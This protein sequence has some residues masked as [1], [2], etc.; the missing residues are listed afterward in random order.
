MSGYFTQGRT[1]ASAQGAGDCFR[2]SVNAAA[3]G[4]AGIVISATPGRVYRLIVQNGAATAYYVQIHNKAT[5]PINTELAIWSKRLPV[6]SEVEIDLT[7]INGLVCTT[8]I[9]IALSSTPLALTL[10]LATDIAFRSVV[11]TKKG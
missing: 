9:S 8:G 4:T 10:A 1:E 6:S 11:Y 5:A 3:E 7:N 2:T